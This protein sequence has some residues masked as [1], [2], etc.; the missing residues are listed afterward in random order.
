MK[1]Q[2]ITHDG[3]QKYHFTHGMERSNQ[4][5]CV[6]F[7]GQGMVEQY[8]LDGLTCSIKLPQQLEVLIVLGTLLVVGF[9][10]IKQCGCKL[11]A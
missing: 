9:D 1:F 5:V 8:D 4:I 10:S 6:H 2:F 7:I 3:W 11:M